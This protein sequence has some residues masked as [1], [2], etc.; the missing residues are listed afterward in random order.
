MKPTATES[1]RSCARSTSGRRSREA[2]YASALVPGPEARVEPTTTDTI[3]MTAEQVELIVCC[4]EGDGRRASE[5]SRRHLD[6]PGLAVRHT[7][8]SVE[9]SNAA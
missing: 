9:G 8:G 1:S 6:R 7:F 2:L 5:L 4:E 3:R